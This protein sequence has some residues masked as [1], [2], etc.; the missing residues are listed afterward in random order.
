MPIL[1]KQPASDQDMMDQVRRDIDEGRAYH[2]TIVFEADKL[3]SCTVCYGDPN[4][5]AESL[6]RSLAEAASAWRLVRRAFWEERTSAGADDA[7]DDLDRIL[8]TFEEVDD[9]KT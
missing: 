1:I 7:A 6:G 4:V 5:E 3:T 9:E 2:A 8:G